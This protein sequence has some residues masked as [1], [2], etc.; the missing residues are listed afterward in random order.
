MKPTLLFFMLGL[1]IATAQTKQ[2]ETPYQ[3]KTFNGNALRMDVAG[4]SIQV[5]GGSGKDVTVEMYVRLNNWPANQIDK[6][7]IEKRLADYDVS[8]QTEGSTVV[9]TSKRKPGINWDSN[10]NISVSFKVFTPVTFTTD[11]KTS[12]GSIHLAHL[13]GTQQ[14]KTSGGSLHLTTIEGDVD[15]RTSGGSIH[16]S[17]CKKNISL[18]TSGGSIH[19]D[20]CDGQLT[21]KTSGGSIH[22]DALKG[23][24]QVSTSGGSIQASDIAGELTAHS[25]GGSIRL[26]NIAAA[27]DA[28]TNGGSIEADISKMTQ[29]VKLRSSSGNVRVN[30]PISQGIDLDIRGRKVKVPLSQFRGQADDDHVSGKLNG[31]GIPVTISANGNVS[32]N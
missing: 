3:T 32:I 16:L 7:E 11:L 5:E 28:E 10:R 26:Q 1:G 4:G 23:T 30:L 9:V 19:A 14:F 2:D 6:A 22:L 18:Q 27:L 31:G 21:M 15:G 25:S 29:Y 20:H 17:E 8:M 24:T 13:K 12:G